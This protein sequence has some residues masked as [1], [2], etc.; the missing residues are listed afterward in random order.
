MRRKLCLGFFTIIILLWAICAYT[1]WSIMAVRETFVDLKNN[2]VCDAIAMSEMK[3]TAAEMRMWTLTYIIRG[4][5]VRDEKRIKEWLQEKWAALEK[6]AKEHLEHESGFSPEEKRAAEEIMDLTQKLISVSREIIDMKDKEGGNE[7]LFEKVRMEFGLPIFYP[8]RKALDEHTAKHY[9]KLTAAEAMV[10]DKH[11]ANIRYI[12]IFGL[13]ITLLALFIGIFVNRLFTKYI[14]GRNRAEKAL[15]ESHEWFSTTLASIGDAVIATDRS[16]NITFMNSIAQKLTGWSIDDA[17]GKS[18]EEIFNIINEKTRKKVENP[19]TRVLHEGIIVGLANHTVLITKDGN[20]VPIDDSGAP[21]RNEKG[22]IIGVVLVFHDIT[23]RR[24]ADKALRKER[25]KAQM[26]LDIAGVILVAINEKGEVTLINR[27]GCQVLGYSDEEIIEKNWFDTCLPKDQVETVKGVFNKLMLGELE[28]VEYFENSVITSRGDERIIAWHNT[29]LKEGDK[30]VGT[31]SSGEDITERKQAEKALAA[32]KERLAVTLT[33]IGDGVIATDTNGTILIFNKIAELLTGWTEEEA[34]GKPLSK[35]FHIKNEQTQKPCENPVEMVL[36]T[37]KIIG[38]ANNTVLVARGG[39]ERIIADSGAPITNE[40]GRVLGVVLVFRDVTETRRLQDLATRAQR[41]ET[42][43]RIAGQVAHDFN[44]LLGPL[45]AFPELARE[46]L[47][48]KHQVIK[49]IDVMEKSAK[50]I[51]DINQQLLTLG[52][53]GHYGQVI[54][55]LNE[56]VMDII[57]QISHPPEIRIVRELSQ[58]LMNIKGGLAQIHRIIANLVNNAID[59]MPEGGVLTIKTENYYGEESLGEYAHIPKGE[60]VKIII[61]DTGIGIPK[62]ISNKIFD[63]FFTTK[64]TDQQ[65]GS[66]LGL[67]VVHAVIEDHGGFIDLE[68]EI[69]K[70]TSFYL[71]F[72]ITREDIEI[73]DNNQLPSGKERILV[74]D[75]DPIQRDVSVRLLE[76]LGY[77]IHTAESGE[78]ALELVKEQAYDLLILDMIMPEGIDGAETYKR[79]LEINPEQKALIVSGFAQ[80]ERVKIA[81]ELGAGE[82]ILKPLTMKSI[83]QAV[84]KA[85]DEKKESL[86]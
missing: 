13:A 39:T 70:G 65:R 1:I 4:N 11:E 17:M 76:K 6:S 34:F 36:K 9:E 15:R 61:S 41:L 33:S 42:A 14:T 10:Q 30:I 47:P 54:L 84:R 60:Y 56:I 45:V 35:V 55:N 24:E 49:Y 25:D 28:P 82:Y 77:G 69:G 71:Y 52:R 27:K 66:G 22:D 59:A 58:N 16:G 57:N 46:E 75:D 21:I 40:E 2:I 32:E 26:Y 81:Q 53:R 8:L 80:S 74:I 48:P 68:S 63:P 67:S 44:N 37:G 31:L 83:A 86:A 50:K 12:I 73:P 29:L 78:K 79:I 85:L 20:E 5:T 38:L 72:P 7:E 43:G 64:K 18:L 62:D 19:V 23:E 3:Y 51:A